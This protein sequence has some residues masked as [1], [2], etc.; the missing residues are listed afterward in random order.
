MKTACIVV[1]A[2][3]RPVT[4]HHGEVMVFKTN[5]AARDYVPHG[6]TVRYLDVLSIPAFSPPTETMTMQTE[7]TYWFTFRT[8]G[9]GDISVSW[10]A[11]NL[12]EAVDGA[13]A[14]VVRDYLGVVRKGY[15]LC[16]WSEK[17]T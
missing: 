3:G 6:G 10:T 7:R 17:T 2:N 5:D 4:N 14:C 12:P 8:E 11:K 9:N 13:W 15:A 1:D 16:G